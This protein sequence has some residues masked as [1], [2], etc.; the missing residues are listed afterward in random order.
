MRS[1]KAPYLLGGYFYFLKMVYLV[2]NEVIT[3]LEPQDYR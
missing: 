2:V 3:T 1:T